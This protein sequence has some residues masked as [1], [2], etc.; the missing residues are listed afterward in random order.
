MQGLDFGWGWGR[1]QNLSFSVIEHENVRKDGCLLVSDGT[2]ELPLLSPL[3]Q[4]PIL[5]PAEEPLLLP[6]FGSFHIRRPQHTLDLLTPYH[7][8]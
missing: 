2:L 3:L 4:P 5:H 6:L 1:L 7:R 8:H